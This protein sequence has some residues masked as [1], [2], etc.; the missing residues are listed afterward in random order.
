MEHNEIYNTLKSICGERSVFENQETKYVYGQLP[1]GFRAGTFDALVLPENA[2]QVQ[3]IVAYASE[4]LI[5][6]TPTGAGL[7]LSDLTVPM[8]G[9]IVVD[10][11]RMDKIIEVNKINRYVVIEAGVTVGH[12]LGYLNKKCPMLRPSVPDA[13]PT[14]TVCGNLLIYGSGH[15]SRY[16]PHSD[17]INE[18]EVVLH[19]GKKMT[20]SS[21]MHGLEWYTRIPCPDLINLFTYW[22]G[23]TGIVTKLSVKLYP[24][25]QVRDMQIFK[26]ENPDSIPDIIRQITTTGLIE[27]VLFFSMIQKESRIPMTL[28]HLFL[29]GEN[30]EELSEKKEIFKE[31]FSGWIKKGKSV[32]P[33]D[34]N[35]LP[36]KFI[37]Q[38]LMEPKYGIDDAVDAKKGGG[39]G[40]I[41]GNFPINSIPKFFHE[42][43]R[44]AKKYDFFGPL[45]TIR[46]VGMG[47]SVIYNVMYPFNRADPAS[48]EI[49]KKAMEEAKEA[50]E[51]FGGIE[52][53]APY[54]TQKKQLSKMPHGTQDLIKRIQDMMNPKRIFNRGNWD[55]WEQ[56]II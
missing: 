36:E 53:K 38:Q 39:C 30:Q 47:H 22:F 10:L 45:Y 41:G 17:M 56:K 1:A 54:I 19:N 5:P 14:A 21:G 9:G 50:I 26:I 46:N 24:K 29:T 33:V 12:L 3:K 35:L 4:K 34:R 28:L 16:G 27:D 43:L 48:I 51:H 18:L 20:L 55:I 15:L 11:R 13:P 31:I 6:L 32:L 8:Y 40:Y 25:H 52:W 37:E 2:E 7:S 44:I 42:G 49:T 23:T